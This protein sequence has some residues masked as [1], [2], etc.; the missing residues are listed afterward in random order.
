MSTQGLRS[1]AVR[2]LPDTGSRRSARPRLGQMLVETGVLTAQ[3]QLRTV[4]LQSRVE[5]RF[6]DILLAHGMIGKDALYDTIARQY[7]TETADFTRTPPD[8]RLVEAYGL[9]R[10]LADGLLPWRRKDGVTE[11]ASARPEQF[12][13]H[14]TA[15]EDLYGPVRMVVTSETDL[16]RAVLDKHPVTLA[17][18]AETRVPAPESCRAW[19]ARALRRAAAALGLLL[20]A[21]L[22]WAPAAVFFAFAAWAILTLVAGTA[23]KLAAA[24]A[25]VRADRQAR[26]PAPEDPDAPIMARLPSVSI[27]VPLYRERAIASRLIERLNRIDY[28][29]EL[30]DICLVVEA[31]DKVTCDTLEAIRLPPHI[32]QIVVPHSTLKTKPRALNYALDFCRGTIVGVY[33]AEDAPAPDQIHRVVR[34]FHER[35]PDV[36]CLQGVLDFYNARTNWVSRCFTIEYAAWFRVLLPGLTRLGVVIPLGGTTLFFRRDVLTELGGW[37]A[38]NVTEDADLGIRLAR[39]GY[40][41]EL[42]DTVTEEEAN[43]WAWPWIKQRSRW[44]K[45][46]MMTWAVHMRAPRRLLAELGPWRFLGIQ[47]LF[48]G[49]IS[50]FLLAPILWSF[51]LV[52]LGAPHP[53]LSLDVPTLSLVFTIFLASELIGLAVAA[54]AVRGPKH[55]F[56]TPWAPVLMLY[57]PLAALAAYKGLAELLFRP[58][59]WD[60]TEHGQCSQAETSVTG[61]AG[62]TQGPQPARPPN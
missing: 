16:H 23:L 55:R 8:I 34:R 33:D 56:L 54:Y 41:T 12:A 9:E 13:D 49:T 61:V 43:C 25:Q 50:Q 21:G 1:S 20:V 5:A 60:K 24:L 62:S 38:H 58:F 46:Y 18:R 59:F 47:L 42:I 37:D 57:F 51:W 2:A 6:G 15:L 26:A 40:R 32:R 3:D 11:I 44:L 7:A 36:A 39:R 22:I 29:R 35:G 4:A 52:P 48:L 14:R 10:C 17:A 28:P 30:L 45:G 19:P 27:L 53:L 31:D